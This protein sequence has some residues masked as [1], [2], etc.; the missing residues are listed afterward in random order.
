MKKIIFASAVFLLLLVIPFVLKP[1]AESADSA[2][3]E[4]TLVIVT[5]HVETIKSE[6]AH[7]FK[8]Y[9]FKKYKN[10]KRIRKA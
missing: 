8:E 5:P 9:Y 4:D 7:A 1:A 2:P 10:H 3:A 6:F